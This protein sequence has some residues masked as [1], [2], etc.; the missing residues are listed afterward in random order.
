[1]LPQEKEELNS[2]KSK[3]FLSAG[4][5]LTGW[6]PGQITFSLII[7]TNMPYSDY[8]INLRWTLSRSFW[9]NFTPDSRKMQIKLNNIHRNLCELVFFT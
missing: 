9:K 5:S 1:M 8:Q 4:E 7:S 3:R 2:S 6:T